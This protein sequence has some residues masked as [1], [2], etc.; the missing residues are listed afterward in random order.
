MAEETTAIQQQF[1]RTIEDW[2]KQ[3]RSRFLLEIRKL[4]FQ[5]RIMWRGR[6]S[7]DI[8]RGRVNMRTQKQFG[9]IVRVR[10]PFTRHGIMQEHGVGRGRKKDSGLEK[11]MPWINPSLDATTPLLADA[12]QSDVLRELGN[13]IQIKVNGIF[14]IELK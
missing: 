13:V 8:L 6:D 10:F 14:E 7:E 3:T 1:N 11:P 9:D 4:P 12:L 2:G 5:Q